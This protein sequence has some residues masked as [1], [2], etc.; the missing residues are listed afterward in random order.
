MIQ[1]SITASAINHFAF[2]DDKNP[3][4][5]AA[6]F[7]FIRSIALHIALEL[8]RPESHVAAG[9]PTLTTFLVGMPE[10]PMNE[11]NRV[12]A[13]QHKVR[14]TRQLPIVKPEPQPPPMKTRPDYEFRFG[15]LRPDAS[16]YST[17]NGRGNRISHF[18]PQIR[19]VRSRRASTFS[20]GIPCGQ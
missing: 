9:S 15:V 11:N 3:P 2:P 10:A 16:H 8:P 5:K 14:R 20:E 6:Q 13:G 4:T 1:L 18:S 12:P 17:T 7:A 19:A